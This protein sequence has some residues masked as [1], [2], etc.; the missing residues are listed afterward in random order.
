MRSVASTVLTLVLFATYLGIGALAHDTHFSLGWALGEHASGL[1]GA[2]A[3]HPDLDAGLGRDRRAG[4]DRGDGQRD[5]AVSDG[6][7]G[8][9]DDAHAAD[10]AASSACWWRISSR[11]QCGSNAIGLL[12]QVPRERRIAFV[13]GLGCRSRSVCLIATAIGYGLAA[14]LPQ[15]FAAAILLLTPLAFLFSTARNCRQLCRYGGAGAR[16]CAVS[17]RVD[18]AYRR[19]HPRSAACP[20]AP[21]PMAFTGGGSAHERLS[22]QFLWRLACAAGAAGRGLPAQRDMA[23]ARPLARRRRRRGFGVSGVGEGGGDRR[24]SPASSR[25]SWCSRRAHWPACRIGCATARWSPVS[26]LSC[27]REGR[28]S[29]A[30]S[31]GEIVMLAGKWWLG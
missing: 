9:A 18:D 8:V 20:P 12:P 22:Q 28:S 2:G 15:L 23:H 19:R 14:N 1:G 29:P 7:V 21:S 16:A 30:W 31:C 3:D 11:S 10:Q 27:W 26:R 6:G 13:H 24:C 5:P 25:K 4:G 17:A